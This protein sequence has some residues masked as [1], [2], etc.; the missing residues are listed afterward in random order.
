MKSFLPLFAAAL[1]WGQQA[2]P[3][4]AATDPVVLTIGTEQ[5]TKSQFEMI[6]AS[7]PAQQRSTI[8]GPEQRRQLAQQLA[9]LK[10]LAQEARKN[11]LDQSTE[12]K[13]RLAL[14]TDQV[15]AN[16]QF[17]A[18]G[19]AAPNDTDLRAFYESHKQDWDEVSARHILIRFQGSQAPL[20]LGAKDL[21]DA[22]ALAKAKDIRTKLLGGAKFA[23]LAQAESDDTGSGANG[24][25]LGAFT[26]GRMVPEF[27]KAAFS[28]PIGEVSEPVRTQ[29]GYHL[30]LVDSRKSKPFEEAR[31]EIQQ[32]LGPEQAQ[33][34]LDDLKN[35]T[36]VVFDESYFGAAK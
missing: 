21:T 19:S 31:A 24:G 12:V 11:K 20:R 35:K 1:A 16:A 3:A 2:P 15:L 28:Q 17:Q 25:D 18:L 13:A 30:I 22:E 14:Q 27:E 4:G 10:T 8:T 34:G 9:E 6:V 23:E 33:K 5:I 26:K 32:R 7:L 29:F 36:N